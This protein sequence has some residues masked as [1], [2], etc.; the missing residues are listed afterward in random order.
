MRIKLGVVWRR[1]A[2]GAYS[3]NWTQTTARAASITIVD[4]LNRF[5]LRRNRVS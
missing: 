4:G 5:L 3:L 2:E 1:G